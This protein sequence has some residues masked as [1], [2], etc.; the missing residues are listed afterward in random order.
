LFALADVDA[1]VAYYASRRY[2]HASDGDRE[3]A[4]RRVAEVLDWLARHLATRPEAV[5]A[6]LLLERDPDL[7]QR[8]LGYR[9]RMTSARL[10]E[11]LASLGT[12][13]DD[14]TDGFL[15]EWRALELTAVSSVLGISPQARRQKL[16]YFL[17][18]LTARAGARLP[19]IL[20]LKSYEP[21]RLPGVRQ[22]P[23][24]EFRLQRSAPPYPVRHESAAPA[25]GNSPARVPAS[26][27]SRA[28]RAAHQSGHA[29]RRRCR[30]RL[31][32]G[33]P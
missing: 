5:F 20:S 8:L 14:S 19:V 17:Q 26:G 22:R 2:L 15:R 9:Q 10:R 30:T 4:S 1:R 28:D 3:Q 13:L 23:V 16:L 21:M 6:A 12:E 32:T 25:R 7:N 33:A 31:R 18:N 27:R 29:S 11:V 24:H